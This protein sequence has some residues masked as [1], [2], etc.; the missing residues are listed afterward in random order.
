LSRLF[1]S[2]ITWVVLATCLLALKGILARLVYAEGVSVDT[3][4]IWR[5]LLAVPFFWLGAIW[6]R[7]GEK[8]APLTRRQILLVTATG[9]LF[10]AS[11]WCDF[12]AIDQLGASISRLLLYVFP[13][14]VMLIQAWQ[15]KQRPSARQLGIF[16]L[17]WC[18]IGMILLPDWQQ[19]QLSLT[20]IAFG[21]GAAACYAVFWCT[22]QPLTHAL[23]SM[24]FNQL[25]NSVTLV[26]V[27][28]LLAPH[29]QATFFHISALGWFWLILLVVFA[30]ALPFF[31][32][33]EGLRR[34]NAGEASL[35]TMFG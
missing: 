3:L 12:H 11:A 9:A 27:L 30:T 15:L 5:F 26:A 1:A 29:Q 8:A 25:S 6:L 20:G 24:R 18:G 22:S 33:F 34:V 2:G 31:L 17:A 7:R 28:L 19:Q 21:I 13:A 35:I 16:V 10:F 14:L 4:L 32:L 23:G